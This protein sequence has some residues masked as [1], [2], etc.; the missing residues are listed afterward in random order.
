[1]RV[2]QSFFISWS[3][4]CLLEFVFVPLLAFCLCS[5]FFF[6]NDTATTEIYTILFVGSVRCVQETGYQRRVHGEFKI[7]I[8][9]L[10]LLFN[11]KFKMKSKKQMEIETFE[12]RY[13]GDKG[14][15]GQIEQEEGGI[16]CKS[17]EGWILFITGIHEETQEDDIYDEFSRFGQIKN[18]H[19]NLD[20]RTG[21]VKGYALV[22]FE[23]FKEASKAI[24]QMNGAEFLGKQIAVDWAFKKP[25]KKR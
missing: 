1:M 14:V 5:F 6:F 22:E 23:S 2:V 7:C 18:Q 17:I 19:L 12:E 10:L 25:S 3:C 16:H 21:Y 13:R 8:F 11:C 9:N 24:E 20:R 4:S 15:F